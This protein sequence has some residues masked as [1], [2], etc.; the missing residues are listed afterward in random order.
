MASYIC[1]IPPHRI[2]NNQ[3]HEAAGNMPAGKE[4]VFY[5]T[6]GDKHKKDYI[7]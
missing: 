5:I 3:Y 4:I 6:T 2:S 1:Y 7:L